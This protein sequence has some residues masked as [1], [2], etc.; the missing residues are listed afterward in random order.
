MPAD[1]FVCSALLNPLLDGTPRPQPR[2]SPPEVNDW[3]GHVFVAPLV[4]AD[5]VAVR[6]TE[7][8]RHPDRINEVVGI[9]P[10]RHALEVTPVAMGV[11]ARYGYRCNR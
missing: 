3:A 8:F 1:L 11:P 10:R 9:N 2:P 6:E 7:E 5:A 4:G